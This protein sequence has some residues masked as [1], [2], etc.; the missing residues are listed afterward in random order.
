[1]E[2]PRNDDVDSVSTLPECVEGTPEMFD[3]L[4]T[5]TCFTLLHC[6]GVENNWGG[7]VE[8]PILSVGSFNITD[9]LSL[10]IV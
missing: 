9:V 6:F 5:F 3:M 4:V 2:K 1:M 8:S 10:L 7:G